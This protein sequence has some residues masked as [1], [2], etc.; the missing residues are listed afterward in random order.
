MVSAA[1]QSPTGSGLSGDTG[2][3]VGMIMPQAPHYFGAIIEGARL[4]VTAA[5][6][7]LVLG[8]SSHPFN[9]GTD[10]IKRMVDAGAEGLLLTPSLSSDRLDHDFDPSW[11]GV[12]VVLV[13]RRAARGSRASALDSVCTDHRSGAA[14]AVR[15]LIDLGH[16]SVALIAPT[17]PTA[18]QV[19]LGYRDALDLLGLERPGLDTLVLHEGAMRLATVE[20]AADRLAEAVTCGQV[21]A[22][23]VVSDTEAITIVQALR[24]RHRQIKV[25]EDL[26]LVAYDDEVAALCNLPLTAVALPKLQVGRTAA[27]LL[28]QRTRERSTSLDPNPAQ[29]LDLVPHLRIRAST[30]APQL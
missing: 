1:P 23:L 26:A 11:F 12:P 5:G 19:E 7:R 8:I 29:H 14:L 2:P 25:P 28:L 24:S 22:A 18:A 9:R 30:H 16:R 6:G 15:H 13:E 27:Q 20:A 17:S 21:S 4:G 3:V 10:Q